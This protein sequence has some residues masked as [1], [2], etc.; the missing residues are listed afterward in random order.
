MSKKTLV[1][2]DRCGLP[3][4][5]EAAYSSSFPY[6]DNSVRTIKISGQEESLEFPYRIGIKDIDF[7]KDCM[8]SLFA[9]WDEGKK[10]E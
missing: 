5:G 10:N 3:I 4:D 7:C 2:C 6:R 9:W 8:V 1:K